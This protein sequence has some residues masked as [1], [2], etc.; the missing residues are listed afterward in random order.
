MND[1][2]AHVKARIRWAGLALGR[3]RCLL[4]KEASIRKPRG[5]QPLGRPK[6][7]WWV[8][9]TKDIIEG[10]TA[11]EETKDR[12]RCRAI[13]GAAKSHLGHKWSCE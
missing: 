10:G 2:V 7:R 11:V 6:K 5:K 13:V 12:E 8:C 1:V 9:I 4:L 3:D